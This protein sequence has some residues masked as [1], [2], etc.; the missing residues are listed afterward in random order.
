MI[1]ADS[2]R[3]ATE[4]DTD[5]LRQLAELDSQQPLAG[6]VLIAR[7]DGTPAAALSLQDG[8]VTADPFRRTDHLIANLRMRARAIRAYDV[9]PSLPQRLLATL[10]A[11]RGSEVTVYP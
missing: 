10:P 9:T 7:I 4:D 1:A 2:I 5:T 3:F 6:R 8:R 11:G